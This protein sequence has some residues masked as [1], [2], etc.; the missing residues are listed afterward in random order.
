MKNQQGIS[1]LLLRV[2]LGIII[3]GHG[4]VK[5]QGGITDTATPKG[6]GF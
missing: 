2:V 6:V 4:T 5:F 1:A 3:I